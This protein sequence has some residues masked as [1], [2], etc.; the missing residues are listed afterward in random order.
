MIF[1]RKIFLRISAAATAAEEKSP[2]KK[3]VSLT[4]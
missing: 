4:V 3:K 2:E 1:M